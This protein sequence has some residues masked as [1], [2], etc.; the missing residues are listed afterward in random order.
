MNAEGN[1]KDTHGISVD[2]EPK[3][4]EKFGEVNKIEYLPDELKIIQRGAR[5]EHFEIVPKVPM[6][7]EK[8]QK[9]LNMIIL[10]PKK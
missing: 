10:T 4:V 8:F 5:P 3:N 2:V 1:V 6:P 9:L 7:L